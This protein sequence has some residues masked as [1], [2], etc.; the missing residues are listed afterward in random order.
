MND[1]R[2]P[3]TS[4]ISISI[5]E[6]NRYVRT[7]WEAVLQGVREFDLIGAYEN[8]EQAFE[9]DDIAQSDIVIMDIGLPGMSGI[10]G[11]RYLTEK[12]PDI[13]VIMCTV[14]DDEEKIFDALCNGAV[15]YLLK[16]ISA[17]DLVQA[18]RDAAAG[19]S[20][21][22]PNIARKVI[23]SFQQ[24]PT[25]T[26][27]KADELSERETNV[28]ILLSEGKSYSAIAQEL[29]LSVDGVRYHIRHIYEKLQVHSRSQAIAKGL[30]NRI[31][32]PPR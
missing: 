28:L 16:K 14:F 17:E 32:N 13:A 12:Y 21:M 3:V 20:P 30:R 8:C 9:T 2:S 24:K 11:V 15:G 25:K 23:T 5:V 31:I 6:D 4:K 7:G 1:K 22:T 26:K 19:G 10:E 29:F 27:H 18:I